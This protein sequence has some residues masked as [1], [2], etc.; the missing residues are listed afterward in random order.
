MIFFSTKNFLQRLYP[1][2]EILNEIIWPSREG[3]GIMQ[4]CLSYA[5]LFSFSLI[6]SEICKRCFPSRRLWTI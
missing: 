4:S 6:A 1:G 5:D 2:Y 3:Q